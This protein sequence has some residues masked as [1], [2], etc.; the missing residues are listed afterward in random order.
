MKYRQ[1]GRTGLEVSELGFGTWGLGGN[2]YGP[3]DDAVSKQALQAAFANGVTFYDT[4]DLYGDG[5]SE[6]ILGEA[7]RHVRSRIILSTKVGLLPHTGFEMPCDFSPR[8]IRAGNDASLRRLKTDYID[9]YLLH[10]PTLDILRQADDIIPTLEELKTAG[11]IRAYGVSVRS[12]DDGLAAV[13]EFG[14][15][16]LEV[17]FNL[18]DQRAL[19]N[20]LFA[21]ALE[22]GAGIIART[23]LCF[24]YLTGKLDGRENL[25]HLD[26]R[27]N[28]PAEQ[29]KRWAQSPN[30][31]AFLNAGKPRTPAQLAL[32]FCLDQR[33][34]S[35]V[36]PGMMNPGEVVE[37]AASSALEP[38][39]SEELARIMLIYSSNV[40]YDQKAK[41][42]GKNDHSSLVPVSGTRAR[43]PA[44]NPVVPATHP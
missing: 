2:S 32:R 29:R 4:S 23:P 3:V 15:Q 38:L 22:A 37:N 31:F 30:L 44:R 17:N 33:A 12:P 28:W 16:A 34:I 13:R 9:L 25:S 27:A 42:L 8:H 18:I 40:F 11:K 21:L 6:T 41:A 20:G 10:S 24:G 19:D 7:L 1:L 26:H 43:D 39:G 35:T 14:F 5:H 36:I